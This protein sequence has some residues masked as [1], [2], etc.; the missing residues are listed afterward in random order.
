M[1]VCDKC[2]SIDSILTF[3][4]RVRQESRQL[5]RLSGS[6]CHISL[7]TERKFL[8]L[9]SNDTCHDA[10][11]CNQSAKALST[12]YNKTHSITRQRRL[13]MKSVRNSHEES[14]NG[15]FFNTLIRIASCHRPLEVRDYVV[16]KVR[17]QEP[18]QIKFFMFRI[19][20][21]E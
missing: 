16:C 1:L 20:A 6:G 13:R 3:G 14:L 19:N 17:F 2:S 18:I 9:C 8:V 10:R 11:A 21:A 5:T 4:D 7:K 15:L 12:Q